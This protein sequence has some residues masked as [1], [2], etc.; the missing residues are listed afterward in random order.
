M[1]GGSSVI[2]P[3]I[4]YLSKE[5]Y[6]LYVF[7]DRYTFS[8]GV[9]ALEDIIQ[10][11]AISIGEGIGSTLNHFG[12]LDGIFELPNTKFSLRI[13]TKYFPAKGNAITSQKDFKDNINKKNLKPVVYVPNIVVD[14]DINDCKNGIDKC[15]QTINEINSD[16]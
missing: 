14:E 13:A 8:S 9:M 12:N 2:K 1:G 10:L 11:G 6:Q 5:N 4:E 16:S 15:M 3:L 7:V